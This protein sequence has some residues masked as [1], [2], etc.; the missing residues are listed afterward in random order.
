ME[1]RSAAGQPI[2]ATP[3]VTDAIGIERLR[4]RIKET[5]PRGQNDFKTDAVSNE[6]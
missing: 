1:F 3:K 4:E 2:G 6:I 5:L